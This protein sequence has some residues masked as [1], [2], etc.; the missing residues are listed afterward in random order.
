MN[1]RD[2]VEFENLEEFKLLLMLR[3]RLCPTP[4]LTPEEEGVLYPKGWWRDTGAKIEQMS[5]DGCLLG[6]ST[7]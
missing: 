6:C 2:V 5:E 4:Y 7:V 1:R 3:S